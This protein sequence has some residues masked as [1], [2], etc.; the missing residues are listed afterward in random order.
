[1]KYVFYLIMVHKLFSQLQVKEKLRPQVLLRRMAGQMDKSRRQPRK[2]IH[3]GWMAEGLKCQV[4]TS[5][6]I[7]KTARLTESFENSTYIPIYFQEI[8]VGS[9]IGKSQ[10]CLRKEFS[11]D[12]NKV[13]GQ[14][15]EEK[16]VNEY[17]WSTDQR[18][19]CSEGGWPTAELL[20]KLSKQVKEEDA[21]WAVS[22]RLLLIFQ[23]AR[24]GIKSG[25]QPDFSDR[26]LNG[27]VTYYICKK[28][29]NKRKK[30]DL[31]V[32]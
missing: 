28:F 5:Y 14:L 26:G 2:K 8:S 32:L 20:E 29:S 22:R 1:M 6:P 3:Q 4:K 23:G 25:K 9:K 17:E 11:W 27:N 21:C 10:N 13:K 24:S 31:T 18:Q 15:G 16:A 12:R 19:K 7:P 30:K